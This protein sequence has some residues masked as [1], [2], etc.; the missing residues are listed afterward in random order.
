MLR[1]LPLLL[2]TGC[3][4]TESLK[5][6]E[7]EY[8]ISPQFKPFKIE[9]L[10]VVPEMG[11]SDTTDSLLL[12]VGGRVSS[13]FYD[14]LVTHLMKVPSFDLVDRKDLDPVLEELEFSHSPFAL[15]AEAPKLGKLLG[16]D[17]VAY[18]TLLEVER[19]V[20]PLGESEVGWRYRIT[21][22]LKIIDVTSGRLLYQATATASGTGA[23]ETLYEVI[24]RCVSPL[25]EL[26]KGNP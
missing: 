16:A 21:G 11:I 18:F 24:R 9:I 12:E 20:Y 17:L 10:A 15:R 22:S 19:I 2:L 13:K 4:T 3:A 5:E 7:V 8:A 1:Y 6:N 25:M 26:S 23:E 14:A